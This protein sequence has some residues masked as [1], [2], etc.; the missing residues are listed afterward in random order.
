MLKRFCLM[1]CGIALLGAVGVGSAGNLASKPLD[2]KVSLG[3]VSRGKAAIYESDDAVKFTVTVESSAD[4]PPGAAVDVEFIELGNSGISYSVTPSRSQTIILPG[5]K[6][7]TNVS[8]KLTT[9][10]G[11]AKTG[12]IDSRLRLDDVTGAT[13]VA[14]TMRDVSITVQAEN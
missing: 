2:A 1:W 9:S 6:D 10:V 11:N 14:P 8:F 13:K 5:G 3:E 7:S 4:V 12:T